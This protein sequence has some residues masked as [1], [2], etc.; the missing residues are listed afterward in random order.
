M[1]GKECLIDDEGITPMTFPSPLLASGFALA[2]MA[3]LALRFTAFTAFKRSL[4]KIRAN[5]HPAANTKA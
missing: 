2:A 4:I 1:A 5:R 3:L